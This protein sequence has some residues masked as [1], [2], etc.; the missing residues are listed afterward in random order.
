MDFKEF[1]KK[2]QKVPVKHY[3]TEAPDNAV[4]SVCVQTYQHV[5]YIRD[6]LDGILMQQTEFPI[7][8]M[9]GEDKSTDGT[10]QICIDYA[11]K[12]PD[13]IRLFLHHR[14]NN[15]AIN[16][17]PTGRFNFI[18]NMFSAKGKYIAL[19]PGDDYWTDPLKLQKQVDFMEENE[20]CSLCYHPAV[21]T[22]ADNS[23]ENTIF[24][25]KGVTEPAKFNIHEF[26]KSV[27]LLGIT[28]AS[29]VFRSS[30]IKELPDYMFKIPTGDIGI[31]FLSGY[32]GK[33][34]FIGQTSMSLHRRVTPGSWS[35]GLHSKDWQLQRIRIHFFQWNLFDEYSGFKYSK[36]IRK[37]NKRKAA[38]V[39]H[40]V[41]KYST[42]KEFI[43]PMLKY[44]YTLPYMGLK[45]F[46]SLT[47]LFILG[48][49]NYYRILVSVKK[50]KSL[51]KK[52]LQ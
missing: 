46:I 43:K 26:I 32:K 22:Y 5:D 38:R 16:G 11:T 15:I 52:Y 14:E 36:E 7:E 6:C 39:L 17:K 30:L 41:Q 18:H 44:A 13:K 40:Q 9:V 48:E 45:S 49:K 24:G 8:I 47:G 21:V 10:R 37:A 12:Y 34:G 19:C 33:L 1:K 20:D 25:P 51:T 28:T 31:K 50:V 27:N 4:V 29:M 2:Y 23:R 42:R 35:A 3:P